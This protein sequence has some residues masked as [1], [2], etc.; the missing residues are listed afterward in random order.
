MGEGQ[1]DVAEEL[2]KNTDAALLVAGRPD[3]DYAN[4]ERLGRA[5]VSG[6]NEGRVLY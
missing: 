2:F 5:V 1:S 4:I 3:Y 6:L